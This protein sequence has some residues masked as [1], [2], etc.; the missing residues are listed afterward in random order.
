[1]L[2]CYCILV[3]FRRLISSPAGI[4]IADQRKNRYLK[5]LGLCRWLRPFKTI[6]L[7]LSCHRAQTNYI[8]LLYLL[9]ILFINKIGVFW[10]A[11]NYNLVRECVSQSSAATILLFQLCLVLDATLFYT[12]CQ[13]KHETILLCK[14][15]YSERAYN[16]VGANLAYNFRYIYHRIS[17]LISVLTSLF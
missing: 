8:W 10:S 6:E 3:E 2:I 15:L 14:G 5:D 11:C 7:R 13:Q 9:N 16:D 17:R 12:N 4:R 1:M